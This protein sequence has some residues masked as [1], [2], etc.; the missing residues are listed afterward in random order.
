M[1]LPALLLYRVKF[2]PVDREDEWQTLSNYF[3]FQANGTFSIDITDDSRTAYV[4]AM[5]C[6]KSEYAAV[7]IHSISNC[8]Y[9]GTVGF[10]GE[11]WADVI[12]EPGQY[13]IA[14]QVHDTQAIVTL[15]NPSSFL[16][17]NVQPCLISRPIVAIVYAGLFLGW[18]INW[19]RNFSFTLTLHTFI[20]VTFGMALL[21]TVLSALELKHFNLSDEETPLTI[22]SSIVVFFSETVFFWTTLMAAKGWSLV[23]ESL[24]RKEVIVSFVFSLILTIP[25]TCIDNLH[26][27]FGDYVILLFAMFGLI[28]YYRSILQSIDSSSA[29]VLAHLL[30]IAESGIDPRTTPIWQ[31]YRMFRGLLWGI[32]GFFCIHTLATALTKFT[33]CPY[34]VNQL[35][36][37][38]AS[39]ALM[40]AAAVLFR[41]RKGTRH[42]YMIIGD[43]EEPRELQRED[44]QGFSLDSDQFQRAQIAWEDGMALPPQPI[45]APDPPKE[46]DV[47]DI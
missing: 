10:P 35:M 7:S 12:A 18:T 3:S 15:R 9:S 14:I 23:K 21:S 42:G 44:L 39:C 11:P 46:R 29:Y 19:L 28:M 4:D 2:S 40:G 43:D 27:G 33:S 45:F 38:L 37:D 5:V 16:D 36:R 24:E 41:L 1:L 47:E 17:A 8:N 32:L 30:V 34:F 22:V 31:K 6:S 25:L 13:Q 26:V 20:T